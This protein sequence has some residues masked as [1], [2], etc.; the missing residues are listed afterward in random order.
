MPPKKGKK[1]DKDG[2]PPSKRATRAKT[3]K[4]K[5]DAADGAAVK[6]GGKKTAAKPAK[7]TEPTTPTKPTTP[8]KKA[9]P[10]TGAKRKRTDGDGEDDDSPPRTRNPKKPKLSPKTARRVKLE[11]YLEDRI[12]DL[13]FKVE[14]SKHHEPDDEDEDEP[15]EEWASMQRLRQRCDDR[16][17]AIEEAIRTVGRGHEF[18]S[19]LDIPERKS[20]ETRHEKRQK[21]KDIQD[22]EE[23]IPIAEKKRVKVSKN[24]PDGRKYRSAKQLGDIV[25]QLERQLGDELKNRKV[26]HPHDWDKHGLSL[27]E[28]L[29]LYNRQ[30]EQTPAPIRDDLVKKCQKYG[31]STVGD[32]W[33]LE[34][35][36]LMYELAN[37]QRMYGLS[38]DAINNIISAL[39]AIK[40]PVDSDEEDDEDG[41]DDSHDAAGSYD[42]LK[43]GGKAKDKSKDGKKD[44]SASPK[45][46]PWVEDTK[47]LEQKELSITMGGQSH[48]FTQV[49]VAPT[50]L[51]C[52]WNTVQYLWM[53]RQRAPGRL[54]QQYPVNERVRDLW[55]AV[56]HPTEGTNNPARQLRHDLYARMEQDSQNNDDGPLEE[57]I[58]NR[59]QGDD[60][61]LQLVAD[62]LDIEIFMYTPTH[63][64]DG[65]T[66]WHRYARGQP[67]N[68]SARQIHIVNYAARNHWAALTPVGDGTIDLPAVTQMAR[69]PIAADTT[70]PIPPLNRLPAG[71]VSNT[72]LRVKKKHGTPEDG[73]VADTTEVAE[74]EDDDEDDEDP[75]DDEEADFDGDGGPPPPPP[76][77]GAAVA[78]ASSAAAR[79]SSS[80]GSHPSRKSSPQAASGHGSRSS[81]SQ[82][83]ARRRTR[84]K[85][86]SKSRNTSQPSG[87]Q[88]SVHTPQPLNKKALKKNH[89]ALRKIFQSFYVAMPSPQNMGGAIQSPYLRAAVS[90]A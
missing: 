62:A 74:E 70:I 66:T 1:D 76:A 8:A 79:R 24:F 65:T 5:A 72:D 16:L 53:G 85:S 55:N 78:T 20:D 45:V 51:R 32:L 41:G 61:M 52:M 17:D 21:D 58:K 27:R 10:A 89:K 73:H 80:S 49:D 44:A 37:K 33:D 69:H 34:K 47:L 48:R 88:K 2:K 29:D 59:Q 14:P 3:V 67:Q 36:M 43:T 84:S 75:E 90:G 7:P 57:R 71:N 31:L 22:D 68:D 25:K 54:A 15:D 64:P 56:M 4:N 40:A 63:G 6:D 46:D 83:R 60:Y 11:S 87:V 35:A 9:T 28:L 26:Q 86:R 50:G 18:Y 30:G 81:S 42:D 77:A 13:G 12:K 23:I 82:K 38:Q 19:N 39:G